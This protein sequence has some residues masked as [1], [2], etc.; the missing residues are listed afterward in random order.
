MNLMNEDL[1][2]KVLIHID[3]I[4]IYNRSMHMFVTCLIHV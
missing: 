1:N 4:Y 2:F 3:Q